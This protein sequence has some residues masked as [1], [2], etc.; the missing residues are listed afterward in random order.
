M[1]YLYVPWSSKGWVNANKTALVAIVLEKLNAQCNTQI[2]ESE[3]VFLNE[4][5]VH[6]LRDFLRLQPGDLV[7]TL[8]T[9]DTQEF[10]RYCNNASSIIVI[11]LFIPLDYPLF[12]N[13]RTLRPKYLYQPTRGFIGCAFDH[14]SMFASSQI[15]KGLT[16]YRFLT[17]QSDINNEAGAQEKV[18]PEDAYIEDIQDIEAC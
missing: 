2:S 7:F 15:E 1:I 8:N 14:F 12:H 16:L 10:K 17:K 18:N 6:L 9:N 4:K 3:K 5:P 13:F 11:T